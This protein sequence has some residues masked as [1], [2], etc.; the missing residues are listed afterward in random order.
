LP[1][2]WKSLSLYL[3]IRR[4]IKETVVIIEAYHFS[5][6]LT[7]LYPISCCQ[8]KLR[9]RRILRGVIRVDRDATGQLL[10]INSA[11][12]NYLIK[13]G[14]TLKQCINYL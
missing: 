7:K 3:F 10:F 2:N 11:L 6:L 4:A 12:V 1:E 14:K 5:H 13:N 8:G 9:M